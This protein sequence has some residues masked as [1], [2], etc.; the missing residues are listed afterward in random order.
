MGPSLG[1]LSSTPPRPRRC[2]LRQGPGS[3]KASDP[4]LTEGVT[5]ASGHRG[6]WHSRP[7][8]WFFLPTGGHPC[9]EAEKLTVGMPLAGSRR[10]LAA[11]GSRSHCSALAT[12][13]V[14]YKGHCFGPAGR[15]ELHACGQ[16][17][18][19][20]TSRLCALDPGRPALPSPPLRMVLSLQPFGKCLVPRSADYLP[21]EHRAG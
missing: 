4:L 2:K 10:L 17:A 11:C 8:L 16:R 9:A 13:R 20:G 19:A 12:P 18:E 15:S 6:G 21:L 5:R 1:P 3:V 7:L 14:L